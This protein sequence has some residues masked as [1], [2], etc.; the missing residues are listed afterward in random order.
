[1]IVI[2]A[3]AL[4]MAALLACEEGFVGAAFGIA[5]GATLG[6]LVAMLVGI[7]LYGSGEWQR[8]EKPLVSLADG[9]GIQGHFFLG[10]GTID[11]RPVYT[12]YEQNGPNSYVR[13]QADAEAATVHY[14]LG[15]G[16]EP[17]YV[18]SVKKD[19]DPFLGTVAVDASAGTTMDE[20]WDFYI[21]RG[22][23][24]RDYTLDNK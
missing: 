20:K 13:R 8:H 14:L 12:W 6:F 10:S 3:C 1:M 7:I 9:S 4:A 21:P 18:R 19:T 15:R 5:I 11:Q 17:F 16:R 22:S 23:I 24:V 2:A